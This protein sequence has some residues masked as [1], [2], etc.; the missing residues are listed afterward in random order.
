MDRLSHRFG[1]KLL[2]Y[3]WLT[4]QKLTTT[5]FFRK[6][7]LKWK[8][9]VPTLK[10]NASLNTLKLPINNKQTNLLPC[11]KA[12]LENDRILSWENVS[13]PPTR[14]L[15]LIKRVQSPSKIK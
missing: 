14:V 5:F 4:S 1:M 3:D 2:D 8:F 11:K 10:P 7:E 15:F 9:W 12:S 6:N 13:V